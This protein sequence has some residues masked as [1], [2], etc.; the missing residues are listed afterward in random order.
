MSLDDIF[1][2]HAGILGI[3]SFSLLLVGILMARYHVQ[4]KLFKKPQR[5]LHG[6]LVLPAFLL[7]LIHVGMGLSILTAL[8]GQFDLFEQSLHIIHIGLALLLVGYFTKVV[9]AGY[10]GVMRCRDGYYVIV[11]MAITIFMGYLLRN[12]AFGEIVYPFL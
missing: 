1:L 6:L 7:S 9:V 10:R 12:V 2:T 5:R 3:I 4:K 11:I 8:F